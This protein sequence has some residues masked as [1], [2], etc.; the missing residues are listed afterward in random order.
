M[1]GI[2]PEWYQIAYHTKEYVFNRYAKHF[3]VLDYIPGG[4]ANLQDMVILKK[5]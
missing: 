2:F 1:K 3:D 5:A 4:L